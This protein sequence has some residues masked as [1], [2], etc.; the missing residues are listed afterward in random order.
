MAGI[1]FLI[2]YLPFIPENIQEFTNGIIPGR[3]LRNND[4]IDFRE[5]LSNLQNSNLDYIN[6]INSTNPIFGWGAGSF[7]FIHAKT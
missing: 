7:N 4:I 5:P 6:R 1:P 3:I 2:N